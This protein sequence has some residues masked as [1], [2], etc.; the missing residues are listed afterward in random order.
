MIDVCSC[1]LLEVSPT[2]VG[3]SG[4]AFPDGQAGAACQVPGRNC[5]PFVSPLRV[6]ALVTRGVGGLE[7]VERHP[8]FT[9]FYGV[10]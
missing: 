5:P 6:G 7:V 9:A 10:E 8:L 2:V 4:M 1:P 3:L